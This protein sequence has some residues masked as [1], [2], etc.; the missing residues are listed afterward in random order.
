MLTVEAFNATA[1]ALSVTDTVPVVLALSVAAAVDTVS[2]PGVPDKARDVVLAVSL[3]TAEPV[4]LSVN[5]VTSVVRLMVEAFPDSVN[6]VVSA[7]LLMNAVPDVLVVIFVVVLPVVI[8]APLVPI[9]PLPDCN[10]KVGV[11]IVPAVSVMAPVPVASNATEVVPLTL[12]CSTIASL[13]PE[14][15]RVTV[16]PLTP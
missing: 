6:V 14:P 15:C 11:V 16:P 8:L 3:T 2:V 1:E 10:V 9:F 13:V 12:A 4:A 5:A 7:L